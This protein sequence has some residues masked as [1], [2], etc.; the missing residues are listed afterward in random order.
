MLG[1]YI[2]LGN[3]V[4]DHPVNRDLVAWW[5]PL[6]NNIGGNRLFDLK[7]RRHAT[8]TNGGQWTL[9][10]NG[11]PAIKGDG[12]DS[13]FVVAND[14]ALQLTNNFTLAAAVR[15]NSLAAVEHSLFTKG[16]NEYEFDIV[17]SGTSIRFNK[18]GVSVLMSAT[19]PGNTAWHHVACTKSGNDLVIYID[20]RPNLGT[21]PATFPGTGT[22]ELVIGSDDATGSTKSMNGDMS[23]MRIYNVALSARRAHDLYRQWRLGHPDTLRWFSRKTYLHSVSGAAPP[24]GNRRRRVIM[25]GSR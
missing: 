8:L 22:R 12:T 20:G 7:G 9:G 4:S 14:S 19:Y 18:D 13:A 17:S 2:D 11:L 6:P 10:V 15:L 24:A 16:A 3:P 21:D 1:R 25:C 23:D 5:Q